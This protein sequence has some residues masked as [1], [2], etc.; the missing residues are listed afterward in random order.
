MKDGWARLIAN[1]G[2]RTMTATITP[3]AQCPQCQET[4][5]IANAVTLL[6]LLKNEFV[7]QVVAAKA[8]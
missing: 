8:A 7:S 1:N 6:A 5:K 4:G 2:R 3:A